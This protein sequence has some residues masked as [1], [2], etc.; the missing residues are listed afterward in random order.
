M[1][2][3]TDQQTN[4]GMV[5]RATYIPEDVRN[6]VTT[7]SGY[8]QPVDKAF[9]DYEGKTLLY[10]SGVACIE[11]SCCGTGTWQ[12]VRVEGYVVEDEPCRD[13]SAEDRLEI[14]TI[15]GVDEKAAISKLLLRRHPGAR[16]EFR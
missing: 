12:Y 15:E 13:R 8:Y 11:A 4:W 9:A 5:A 1:T 10:T 6:E 2:P 16:I 7:P 3:C 14:E